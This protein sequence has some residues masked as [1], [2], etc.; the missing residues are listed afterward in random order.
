MFMITSFLQK[1][2][3]WPQILALNEGNISLNREYSIDVNV[4]SYVEKVEFEDGRERLV[5]WDREVRP[6]GDKHVT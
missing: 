5:A 1:L 4:L 3:Q 6:L 2:P